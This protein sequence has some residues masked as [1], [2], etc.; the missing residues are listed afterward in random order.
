MTVN[1]AEG[2]TLLPATAM[3]GRDEPVDRMA[4]GMALQR[5]DGI[6]RRR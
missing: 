3:A 1:D 6:L 5:E 2:P 4:P